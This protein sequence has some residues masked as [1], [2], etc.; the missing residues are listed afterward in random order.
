MQRV[1][2]RQPA[3]ADYSVLSE[4]EPFTA[5]MAGCPGPLLELLKLTRRQLP[6]IFRLRPNS[7][8]R[9]TEER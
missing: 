6:R 9:L 5:M 1:A 2:S 8:A 7:R 4:L 3:G